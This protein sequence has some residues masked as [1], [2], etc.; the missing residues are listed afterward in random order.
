ML[1]IERTPLCFEI[2]HV[3]VKITI[4]NRRNQLVDESDFK[5][6]YRMCER[7]VV[8]IFTLNDSVWIEVAEFCLVF[9]AVFGS[10]LDG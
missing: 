10:C 6:F 1:Y 7:A 3:E 4:F 5:V 9:L 2:A 8:F